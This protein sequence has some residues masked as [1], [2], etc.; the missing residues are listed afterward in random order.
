MAAVSTCVSLY[1]TPPSQHALV[2]MV[3]F[4]LMDGRVKVSCLQNIGKSVLF[5][6]HLIL[7]ISLVGHFTNIRS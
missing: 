4:S 3:V 2:A 6:G 7:C 1:P 5:V